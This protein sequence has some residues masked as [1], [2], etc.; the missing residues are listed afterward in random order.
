MA[1]NKLERHI[2]AGA[3]HTFKVKAGS[4]LKIGDIVEV[5]G[6]LEVTKAGATSTKVIGVVYSGTVGIDGVT[7]GYQGNNGDVVT[8]ITLKPQVYMTTGGAVTAG[9][10]LKSDANGKIVP[11][12]IGTD[13]DNA[14]VGLALTAGASGAD[15]VVLLG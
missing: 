3:F 6:D 9:Q 8:V 12:V 13:N 5:S 4:T 7:D 2:Q 11:L 1:R 15:V 14:R 10:V